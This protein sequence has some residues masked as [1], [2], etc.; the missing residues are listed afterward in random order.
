MT[1][2]F[3]RTRTLAAVAA[4]IAV[5]VAVAMIAFRPGRRGA[6]AQ[7][8]P[9][10]AATAPAATAAPAAPSAAAAAAGSP[11]HG[12]VTID[13]RRQ[14]LIGVRTVPV[15]RRRLSREIRAVGLVRY[16]ETRVADV[17][18]KVEAWI[19]TLDV[20]FTGQF[21][22][23]GQ[24]LFTVYSP[25]LLTTQQ[26]YL[27]A[28]R[29]Q[30]RAAPSQMGETSQYTDRLVDSAR[31]RLALWDLPPEA[32]R[33]IEQSQQPQAAVA[34]RSPVSGFVIEKRAVQGMHA[35]AGESL[36]RI[37]DLS[38]VWVEADIYE[39]EL[40]SLRRGATATI[41]L[42][43]YP[44]A[45]FQG[46]VIYISAFVDEKTRT[47]K[48]RFELLNRDGRL[49]PGMYANVELAAPAQEGLAVPANAVLDSGSEQIVFV[50]KG[51]GYFEPRRVTIGQRL[52]DTIEIREGL[53]EGDQVATGATFFLDSESQLRASLQGFE[54]AQT[55]APT[56]Q[57]R[58][59]Q[60]QQQPTQPQIT[61]RSQPDPPKTGEN[62]LEVEVK[63][64]DGKPVD[65]AEVTIAFYMAAMPTMNMPAMRNEAKLPHVGNGVYRGMGTVMM[66]ARWE[67]TVN[68][69]RA[70]QRIG[71]KHVTVVAR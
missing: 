28:L 20:D 21:V 24:T 42:D 35:N 34:F 2:Q 29:A 43:A 57:L 31:R 6:A 49:K 3:R 23:K 8:D 66:A 19:R 44:G 67:V 54:S 59:P 47:V 46:R 38:T 63:T 10:H 11:A 51:E 41:T 16:D 56:S 52:G 4:A 68:V 26:E 9:Q 60:P 18:L 33:A 62:L 45:R 61:F 37:A 36:Y 1:M 32:I 27:L 7:S 64:P 22:R 71:T 12:D 30:S 40:P 5:A 70:G 50:A 58:A 53:Q 15:E 25:E 48:A 17:N 65:D 55:A 13:P 14:Q 69:S 39:R